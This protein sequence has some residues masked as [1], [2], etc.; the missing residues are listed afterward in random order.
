MRITGNPQNALSI[1]INISQEKCG[2]EMNCVFSI[3]LTKQI[4]CWRVS[5]F[6]GGV[7]QAEMTE[8]CSSG[9]WLVRRM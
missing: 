8:C 9:K 5:I 1:E 2:I 6:S 7:W 4:A 3:I